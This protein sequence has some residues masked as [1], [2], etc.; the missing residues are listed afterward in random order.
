MPHGTKDSPL[1]VRLAP[2]KPHQALGLS[3]DGSVRVPNSVPDDSLLI[4]EVA[5]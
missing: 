2:Q 1:S 3:D 5:E 4:G